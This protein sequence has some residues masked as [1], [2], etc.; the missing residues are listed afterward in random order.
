MLRTSI[1]K[2]LLNKILL[3]INIKNNLQKT[4]NT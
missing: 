2:Y 4:I 3:I 1:Q